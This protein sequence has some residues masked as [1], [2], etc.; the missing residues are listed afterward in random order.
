MTA[1]RARERVVRASGLHR[2]AYLLGRGAAMVTLAQVV[3]VLLSIEIT[4]F[5]VLGLLQGACACALFF[6][7]SHRRHSAERHFKRG[8]DMARECW[9]H[10]EWQGVPPQAI[11]PQ[12]MTVLRRRFLVR[13]GLTLSALGLYAFLLSRVSVA[14]LLPGLLALALAGAGTVWVVNLTLGRLPR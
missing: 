5:A 10:G 9:R 11:P 8:V 13:A 4:R 2:Q 14:M 3:T 7:A 1:E 12:A 6:A